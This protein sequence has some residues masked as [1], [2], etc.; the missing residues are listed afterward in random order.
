M[1]VTCYGYSLLIGLR[2]SRKVR[3]NRSNNNMMQRPTTELELELS[4]LDAEYQRRDS[5]KDSDVNRYSLFNE[6]PLLHSQ[7]LERNVLALLKRHNFTNL[8]EKNILDVGCGNG[9]HLLRF[10]EY[11]A[12]PT[13]LFGI[14]L[15]A[16]RIEQARQRH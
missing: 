8:T 3:K 9:G 7:S 5:G 13:N 11:G 2:L 15:M 14:D 10:L 16:S 6:S 4:R 12:L 1:Y